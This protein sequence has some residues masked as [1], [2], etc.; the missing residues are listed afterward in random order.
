[1]HASFCGGGRRPCGTGGTVFLAYLE[2]LGSRRSLRL[3]SLSV[4][5]RRAR[6]GV[7]RGSRVKMASRRPH[8]VGLALW[9]SLALRAVPRAS[10]SV[11]PHGTAQAA[12][13]AAAR[14]PRRVSRHEELSCV[15]NIFPSFVNITSLCAPA[16][17]S[18]KFKHDAW[19]ILCTRRGLFASA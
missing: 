2:H 15:I 11:Q 16:D 18:R 7:L 10:R 8:P 19:A 17:L 13:P 3:R 5:S 1:M 6:Q 14:R 4:S 9:R 12:P